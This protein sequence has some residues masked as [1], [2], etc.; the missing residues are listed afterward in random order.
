MAAAPATMAMIPAPI[1]F[2]IFSDAALPVSLGAAL[3]VGLAGCS[4][5]LARFLLLR[6]W[7]VGIHTV[8]VTGAHAFFGQRIA[9]LES[10]EAPVV[11]TALNVVAEAGCREESDE[12]T[13]E[14]DEGEGLHVCGLCVVT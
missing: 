8:F 12:K 5:W 7:G 6:G 2:T 11:S 9:G 4:C 1:T 13:E 14:G 10:P 3:S